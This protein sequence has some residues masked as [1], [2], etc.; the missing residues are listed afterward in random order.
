MLYVYPLQWKNAKVLALPKSF[1]PMSILPFM[2]KVF[3]SILHEQISEFLSENKILTQ[4]QSGYR[5]GHN[6][7]SALIKVSED[8]RS[9]L[10]RN[11]ITFLTL[12]DHSKAFDTINH[13]IL[14]NKLLKFYNFSKHA[15]KHL[16]SLFPKCSYKRHIINIFAC[17]EWCSPRLSFR[18][19]FVSLYINDLPYVLNKC[20]IHLYADD[21]QL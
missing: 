20:K 21:V 6:C 1:R 10:D 18:P 3:E 15:V 19:P 13:K 4:F 7:V 17:S 14:C 12:L 16:N 2:S 11:K 8:I 9:E 5:A